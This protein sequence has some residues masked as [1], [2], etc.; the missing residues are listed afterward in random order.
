MFLSIEVKEL[1]IKS[2]ENI[3]NESEINML[4]VSHSPGRSICLSE[5]VPASVQP[6]VSQ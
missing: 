2:K 3:K 4:S 5:L 1:F 6:V